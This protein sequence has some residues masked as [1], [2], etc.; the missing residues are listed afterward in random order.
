MC[1]VTIN[2]TEYMWSTGVLCGWMWWY[3]ILYMLIMWCFLIWLQYLAVH[4]NFNKG[5]SFKFCALH[6]VSFLFGIAS[7]VLGLKPY[8]HFATLMKPFTEAKKKSTRSSL[9][10][11]F[12]TNNRILVQNWVINLTH[13]SKHISCSLWKIIRILL[14]GYEV[15]WKSCVQVIVW[16]T[17]ILW[18]FYNMCIYMYVVNQEE[19]L[20][21]CQKRVWSKFMPWSI[22]YMGIVCLSSCNHTRIYC[23]RH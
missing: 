10:W 14:F 3:M 1:S 8:L 5:R 19:F 11:F 22:F 12:E 9:I 18:D 16:S 15:C 21:C 17:C 2:I 20:Q 23:R 7:R 4:K 6:L 13:H